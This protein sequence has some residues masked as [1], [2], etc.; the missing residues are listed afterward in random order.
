M[1]KH[2]TLTS[3]LVLSIMVNSQTTWRGNIV[4]PGANAPL[5]S[6]G[7]SN[8][9]FGIGALNVPPSGLNNTGVGINALRSNNAGSQNTANGTN[10]LYS[11]IGGDWNT[12]IGVNALFA[13]NFGTLNTALGST[14]L[15]Q[16]TTGNRNTAAGFQALR[17][18][19]IGSN[20]TACGFEALKD[21]IADENTALGYQALFSNTIGN[22]NVAVGNS[23]LLANIDGY[24]NTATGFEALVSNINGNQNTATG[25]YAMRQNITGIYNTATGV[26]ALRAN[27]TGSYNCGNGSTTLYSNVNGNYNS[28]SGFE[29]MRQNISGSN[30]TANGFYAL[31]NNTTADFNTADGNNALFANV[32]G[33]GNTA[34]GSQALSNNVSGNNNT[35]I[36]VGANVFT[37]NLNNAN[38]IGSN[39]I[40]RFSDNMILGDNNTNVGIGL[41]SDPVG[42]QNKLEINTPATSPIPGAS[43]LRFRDLTNGSNTQASNNKVLSVNSF[44]DVILVSDQMGT[45]TFAGAL[46]GCSANGN[47]QVVLG[48]DISQTQ[49]TLLSNREIPMNDYLIHFSGN[50]YNSKIHVGGTPGLGNFNAGAKLSVENHV[51]S[52]PDLQYGYG[53]YSYSDYN[54]PYRNVAVAGQ[55]NDKTSTQFAQNNIAVVAEAQ[56]KGQQ[57]GVD[58]RSVASPGSNSDIFGV[59]IFAASQSPTSNRTFGVY[60]DINNTGN[61][62]YGYGVYAICANSSVENYGGKFLAYQGGQTNYGIWASA[63]GASLANWAAYFNGAGYVTG[64]TWSGSDQRFKKDIKKIESVMDK[65]QKLNA[66]TYYYRADEFKEKNYDAKKHYGF[67]AQELKEI[68]PEMVREDEKGYYAVEYDAM[69]PILLEAIKEQ[70]NTMDA[71]NKTNEDLKKR[72]DAQGKDIEE[73]KTLINSCCS[74]GNDGSKQNNSLNIELSDKNAIVLNQNVPNPFA[75]STVI[76]YTIPTDFGKAQIIFS[77]NDGK[78][79]KTVDIVAKG[80]GRLTV[81]AND[82]TNGLYTYSLIVDG[83]TEATKKMVKQ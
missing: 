37:G 47:N 22:R 15:F 10:A 70:Q 35:A 59:N 28:A 16:N 7:S 50:Q 61:G 82:L 43:G 24:F 73:L 44:G 74:A 78:V 52:T 72:M 17:N 1:K 36:G 48:N 55:V 21:N 19:I 26:N 63:S 11:N 42:P 49:A 64:G 14:A 40:V 13:N 20:N 51:N 12:G 4:N 75:E 23:A 65:V 80:T 56:G 30:N 58:V 77:T 81:Y 79:I 45:G 53:I 41:S 38:A 62:P 9:A 29:A 83:K 25:F 76:N 3:L 5:M 32:N 8:C 69:I 39:A 46:N 67:I 68:F 2:I 27:T 60:T 31:Y 66:Y 6:A 18:N 33:A 54:S 57:T 71:Q 34:C